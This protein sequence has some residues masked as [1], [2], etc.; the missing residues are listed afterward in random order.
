MQGFDVLVLMYTCG[1]TGSLLGAAVFH[2]PK[3]FDDLDEILTVSLFWPLYAYHRYTKIIQK[4]AAQIAMQNIH[5]LR[6]EINNHLNI[7]RSLSD[8]YNKQ[9]SDYQELM[10]KYHNLKKQVDG[11]YKANGTPILQLEVHKQNE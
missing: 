9:Q 8:S 6:M 3:T 2:F 11:D 4:K 5:I 7:I 10:M 1:I